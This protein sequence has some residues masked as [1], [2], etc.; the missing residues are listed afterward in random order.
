VLIEQGYAMGRPSL[1]RVE[2]DGSRIRLGGACV[3]VAEG[4]LR[5]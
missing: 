1:L 4:S 5:V 3:I 2:V